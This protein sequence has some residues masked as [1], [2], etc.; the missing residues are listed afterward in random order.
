M[1]VTCGTAMQ[2]CS[3]AAPILFEEVLGALIYK[4]KSLMQK[5]TRCIIL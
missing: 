2:Y 4:H 3:Q 5:G 1:A